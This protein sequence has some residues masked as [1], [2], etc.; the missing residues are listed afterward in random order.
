VRQHRISRQQVDG[1]Y[2]Y[3]AGNADSRRR[4]L[5]ARQT[6]LAAPMVA[7]PAALEVSPDELK[8][9][10]ILFYSLLDEKQR[11]LYAGLESLKLGRG[12]D[13]QLS[14]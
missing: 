7:D 3:T 8:A 13:G 10:I 5:L 4:Q 2:L 12:G 1:L 14:F 6:E 9:A 11:R